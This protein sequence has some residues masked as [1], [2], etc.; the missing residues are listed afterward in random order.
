MFYA[1]RAYQDSAVE[2][3]I[4]AFL[5]KSGDDV[6]PPFPAQCG[7]GIDCHGLIR[8]FSQF[9]QFL[10]AAEVIAGK[11]QLR[12]DH[13]IGIDLPQCIHDLPDIPLYPAK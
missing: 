1:V 8:I 11:G 2:T 6:K 5:G 13:E 9:L 4:Q 10:P 3:F 12:Q 7:Q